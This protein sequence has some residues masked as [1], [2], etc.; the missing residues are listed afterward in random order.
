MADDIR[1]PNVGADPQASDAAVHAEIV[2][3][4][5]DARILTEATEQQIEQ[6]RTLADGTVIPYGARQS[7]TKTEAAV[8]E[9]ARTIAYPW[10]DAKA[11]AVEEAIGG[12]VRE[13]LYPRVLLGLVDLS[14]PLPRGND[15]RVSRISKGGATAELFV[16]DDVTTGLRYSYQAQAANRTNLLPLKDVGG[17]VRGYAWFDWDSIEDGNTPIAAAF[18]VPLGPWAKSAHLLAPLAT[19][20]EGGAIQTAGAYGAAISTSGGRLREVREFCAPGRPRATVWIRGD[21]MAP[22]RANRYTTAFDLGGFGWAPHAG[23][24]VSEVTQTVDGVTLF[25]NGGWD[26]LYTA[27][28]A[29]TRDVKDDQSAYGLDPYVIMEGAAVQET[30]GVPSGVRQIKPDALTMDANASAFRYRFF[31][32]YTLG[33]EDGPMAT[34]AEALR[35]RL[36]AFGPATRSQVY[37]GDIG[38]GDNSNAA[39]DMVVEA[40]PRDLVDA[41]IEPGES[42]FYAFPDVD[43]VDTAG[44]VAQ[45]TGVY[46]S[47]NASV[48]EGRGGQPSGGYFHPTGALFYNPAAKSGAVIGTAAVGSQSFDGL[49]ESAAPTAGAPK[50]ST[51]YHEA[52]LL[53]ALRLDEDQPLLV[54][55]L[56][57]TEQGQGADEA[58]RELYFRDL[59]R[60]IRERV[61]Y[62]AVNSGHGETRIFFVQGYAQ[63]I[64]YPS[65]IDLRTRNGNDPLRAAMEW[66]SGRF[67]DVS[68]ASIWEETDRLVLSTEGGDPKTAAELAWVEREGLDGFTYGGHGPYDMTAEPFLDP[69]GIHCW[70]PAGGLAIGRVLA[71][72]IADA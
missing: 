33:S 24:F 69:L 4:A 58:E 23:H 12:A 14:L 19:G 41:Q 44:T 21:S 56:L 48:Q 3:Y 15:V 71:R 68:F 47:L 25:N 5:R 32:R 11:Y 65:G 51:D 17:T 46:Y 8:L 61:H 45:A 36:I 34:G 40:A 67:Q 35:A 55:I 28:D 9:A 60:K 39:A 57:N 59:L 30:V 72:M 29:E 7:Y 66:A 1:V 43:T 53:R 16:V 42:G 18:G 13:A 52:S 63:H 64:D 70:A 54:P 49:A 50:R 38:L 26:D 6:S 10:I 37:P 20:E 31:T 22:R 27:S 62:W 2:A